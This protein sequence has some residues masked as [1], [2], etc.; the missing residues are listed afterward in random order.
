MTPAR[1]DIAT[2]QRRLRH[3]HDVLGHL[4]DLADITSQVLDGDPLK[5]AA[6][7]RL[8]QVIVDL[9]VDI[10]GHLVVALTGRAPETGRSSF[11]DLAACGVISNAL[12]ER[13]APSAG[14]RNV[15]VHQYID[16]RTD[17]VAESIEAARE[18][19]PLYIAA[20]AEFCLETRDGA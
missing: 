19:F 10:N 12:A 4:E 13:L 20:V 16:I 18:Q 9:A 7:E 8:L 11:G 5:R 17:L 14:L 15:L 2:V 3:L 1:L 6:A